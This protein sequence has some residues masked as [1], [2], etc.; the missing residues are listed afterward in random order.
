[1]GYA[2]TI[3]LI[4]GIKL[5]ESQAEKVNELFTQHDDGEGRCKLVPDKF[6]LQRDYTP[7][8]D[9]LKAANTPISRGMGHD[10]GND[11]IFRA[12]LVSDGTDSR[13]DSLTYDEG[14]EHVVGILIGSKGYAYTDNLTLLMKSGAEKAKRNYEQFLKPELEKLGIT[15]VPDF[16]FVT[17]VW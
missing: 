9:D 16:Q 4:W 10:K 6:L 3:I 17:Q 8:R 13:C 14:Y 12:E 11:F 2:S 7:H 1:M 5:S 15:D